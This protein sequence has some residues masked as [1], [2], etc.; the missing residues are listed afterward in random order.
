MLM[1][2]LRYTK[3]EWCP[4]EPMWFDLKNQRHFGFVQ[5]VKSLESFYKRFWQVTKPAPELAFFADLLWERAALL[6]G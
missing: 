3:Q 1:A 5:I 2:I 4:A 6:K